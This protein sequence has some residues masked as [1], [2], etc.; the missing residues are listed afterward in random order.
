M[1]IIRVMAAYFCLSLHLTLGFALYLA[2]LISERMAWVEKLPRMA[3]S[4][5]GAKHLRRILQRV[6]GGVKQY[7][8]VN[9]VT[10]AM[11]GTVAYVIFSQVGLDFAPLLAVI[12]FVVGFI[13]T[14]GAFIGVTLPSLVALL[15]FDSLTPFL[16]VLLGYG[17][18][19]QLMQILY[20]SDAD[21]RPRQKCFDPKE[22]N[23]RAALDAF[24][25]L[26]LNNLLDIIGIAVCAAVA[27]AWRLVA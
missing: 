8:W 6:A 14:I 24:Q 26:A 4:E 9:V 27:F 3:S 10:S 22:V 23:Y 17:L 7:M 19:D 21:L 18:A 12:V 15:Q 5:A 11:S 2:F 25:E 20:M 13:P 1:C 16:I